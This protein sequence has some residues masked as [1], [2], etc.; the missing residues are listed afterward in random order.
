MWPGVPPLP[1]AWLVWGERGWFGRRGGGQEVAKQAVNSQQCWLHF[2]NIE[3]LGAPMS[4]W[5]SRG[6]CRLE[7]RPN[8]LWLFNLEKRLG[9]DTVAFYKIIKVVEKRQFRTVT[10]Q[11]LQFVLWG[12]DLEKENISLSWTSRTW[13]ER[14]WGIIVSVGSKKNW[15]VTSLHV[16]C[17][18]TKGSTEVPLHLPH[19]KTVGAGRKGWW[20]AEKPCWRTQMSQEKSQR[21]L[22]SELVVKFIEF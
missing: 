7:G 18:W 9:W 22:K 19:P 15:M 16:S 14:L 5:A 4:W 20:T 11:I 13:P 21:S 6:R 2:A 10:H 12:M 1:L 3:N 17:P 8:R